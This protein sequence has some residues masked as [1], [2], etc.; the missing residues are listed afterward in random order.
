[1]TI[2]LY[3]FIQYFR[4]FNLVVAFGYIQIVDLVSYSTFKW[5]LSQQLEDIFNPYHEELGRTRRVP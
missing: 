2:L 5:R 4:A 3:E 1:M